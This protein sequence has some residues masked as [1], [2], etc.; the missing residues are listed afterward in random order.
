MRNWTWVVFYNDGTELSED[1]AGGFGAVDIPRV[2]TLAVFDRDEPTVNY[3][4]PIREGMRPIFFRRKRQI[5]IND[6]TAVPV[7]YLNENNE[8]TQMITFAVVLGWQKTV[9]GRNVKSLI[10]LMHDGSV[11]VTDRDLDELQGA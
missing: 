6:P 4:V 5:V 9:N 8:V 2:A 3:A 10:W 7:E 11:A 1:Q